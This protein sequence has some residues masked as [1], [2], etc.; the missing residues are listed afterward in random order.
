MAKKKFNV[1]DK[2]VRIKGEFGGMEV[3][4]TDVIIEISVN[5]NLRLSKY[6]NYGEKWHDPNNF[7]LAM[8]N[9]EI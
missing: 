3:F 7:E 2:V 5:K 6:E 4:D 1:G 9:N 8:E